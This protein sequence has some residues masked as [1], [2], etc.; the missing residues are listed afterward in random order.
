MNDNFASPPQ[1]PNFLMAMPNPVAPNATQATNV[2]PTT[3]ARNPNDVV[4]V[5]KAPHAPKKLEFVSS[6][7]FIP[8]PLFRDGMD[9]PEEV[10]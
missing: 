10:Y 5:P 9:V 1:Q 2:N 7:L 3:P 6:S 4:E 8:R